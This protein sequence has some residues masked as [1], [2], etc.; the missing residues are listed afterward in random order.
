[1]SIERNK[2]VWSTKSIKNLLKGVIIIFLHQ[3]TLK[4]V[5]FAVKVT[6][7]FNFNRR[8]AD[9]SSAPKKKR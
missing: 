3:N 4:V 9:G 6:I 8:S 5:T 1:M 2:N 7:L